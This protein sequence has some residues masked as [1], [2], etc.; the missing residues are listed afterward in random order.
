ME[1]VWSPV[2]VDDLNAAVD[3]IESE[4][5]SPMA[6]RRL[7]D[8][9][10]EKA[11][12]FA[13]VSGAGMAFRTLNRVDT[14]YRYM[15][16]EN[17]MVFLKR[18]NARCVIAVVTGSLGGCAVTWENARASRRPGNKPH[19]RS[20]VAGQLNPAHLESHITAAE[21]VSVKAPDHDGGNVSL[22]AFSIMIWGYLGSDLISRRHTNIL[23][24]MTWVP[25]GLF[26]LLL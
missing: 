1:L 3:C 13:D 12:L 26:A 2:A 23:R 16:S 6:A 18:Y 7:V 21:K 25:I 14:G 20:S 9:V 4:L 8:S 19:Q 11:P 17:W 10:V 5:A 24:R 22:V 15:L